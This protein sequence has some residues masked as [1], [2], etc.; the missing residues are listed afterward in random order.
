MQSIPAS[1]L[2][3]ASILRDFRSPHVWAHLVL[4]TLT[5]L[6]AGFAGIIFTRDDVFF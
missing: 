3:E 1:S 2:A 4:T 6:L 5:C